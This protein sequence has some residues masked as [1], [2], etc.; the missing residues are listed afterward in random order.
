MSLFELLVVLLVSFLVIK[1]EDL[2]KI[3]KKIRYFRSFITDTKKEIISYLDLDDKEV[4]LSADTERMNFYLEKIAD[5]E[6]DYK[7]EYS[8]ESIKKHYNSLIKNKL[9]EERKKSSGSSR[10]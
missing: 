2:P 10:V 5:M 1:P 6:S 3:A 8:I 9:E 7:G 4:E